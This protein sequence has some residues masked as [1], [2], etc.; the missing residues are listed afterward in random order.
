MRPCPASAGRRGERHRRVE[1]PHRC[2]GGGRQVGHRDNLHRAGAGAG[3]RAEDPGPQDG[4][5]EDGGDQVGHGEGHQLGE[6]GGRGDPLGHDQPERREAEAH[7]V[8]AAGHGEEPAAAGL[9][10]GGAGE[11]AVHRRVEERGDGHGDGVG[12]EG[13]EERPPGDEEEEVAER[14]DDAHAGEAQELVGR[15]LVGADAAQTLGTPD[16]HAPD[17]AQVVRGGRDDLHARVGV[18]DPVHRDLADAQAQA[19][20]RDQQLGVEEP[21]VVL[22]ERQQL[23]RRVAAQGLEAALGVAEAAAAA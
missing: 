5:P 1:D 9:P 18:V 13:A 2:V 10:V 21:L 20:G 8:E 3:A 22:N 23:L 11:L 16:Q 4:E 15:H 19:L 7:Q 17:A 12:A 14:G 6:Q